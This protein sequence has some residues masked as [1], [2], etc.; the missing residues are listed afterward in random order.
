[1]SQRRSIYVVSDSTGETGAKVVQAALLQFRHEQVN[2][3]TF[4]NLRDM[5]ALTDVLDR[6]AGEGALVVYTLVRADQRQA[7]YNRAAEFGVN[8][9]DLMGNLMVRLGHW[10]EASPKDEPGLLHRMDE[11]YFRRVEAM[12]FA[13]KHDDGQ[14]PSGMQKAEIVVV[15]VSRT[16][17]TPVCAYLAQRGYKAANLPLVLDVEP[18]SQV[19]ELDARR[20]FGLTISPAV[21]LDIRRARLQRMGVADKSEYADL[22]YIESEL[23]HAR[24]VYRKHPGWTVLDVTRRAVEETASDLVAIYQTRFG[25]PTI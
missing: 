1:M 25:A 16:S 15:G 18:P 7:L 10:L 9:V 17:K 4:G 11:E 12:E 2:L 13:V 22:P 6:A 19:N 14:N 3:R 21:L 5:A 23:D 24:K 8:V 20:V